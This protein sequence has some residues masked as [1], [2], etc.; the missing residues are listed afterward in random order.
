MDFLIALV[1][2]A[3]LVWGAV[4]M[5]R[6]SLMAGC[7]AFVA[8]NACLGFFFFHTRVGPV[9]LT[10]DRVIL[11]L[12]A[13]AYAIH[14]LVGRTDPK[15]LGMADVATLAF[16]GWLTVRTFTADWGLSVPG[17]PSPAWHLVVGYLS[18]LVLYWIVR[19]SPLTERNV[20]WVQLFF[21]GLGV[22]LALTAIAEVTHQWW[23]V[24][25]KHIADPTVGL[26][27]GR[28]RGPMVQSI[29]LGFTLGISL[30]STWILRERL[31]GRG[32]IAMLALAAL[33]L[34]GI[35]FTYT[36]CVW[37]GAGLAMLLVMGLT[38]PRR[39]SLLLVGGLLSV[40]LVVAT[41]EW[42]T[43][44][45]LDAGRSAAET[46]DS[47]YMR[48]SFAYVS[49]Q[50]FQDHPLFGIGFGQY[51]H[52]HPLYLSDRS[53]DLRLEGIRGQLLH[54][55]PLSILVETG[56]IGLV[57]MLAMLGAWSRDAWRL[58]N[59]RGLPDWVRMHGLL[60][61]GVVAVYIPNALFQPLG[62]MN[63]VHMMF[64][65]LSGIGSGLAARFHPAKSLLPIRAN[66]S[67]VPAES[68]LVISK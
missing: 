6:G 59:D 1:V 43:L 68:S 24:F 33:M 8:V 60:M 28:A 42:D 63:P 39:L 56:L 45:N 44:M 20:R 9:E 55:L 4:Y 19:Q 25:P 51:P 41:L 18:P 66:R 49:W 12:L 31:T 26:H 14:R 48:A 58:W 29:V 47:T 37:I 17:Q 30:I 10:L 32:R 16:L 53:T 15:P 7:L 38:L 62:H 2:V 65:L 52:E 27:F 34:V 50:M 61:L 35:F 3:A 64:F 57:L 46:R 40:S 67:P 5:V 54:N 23:A 21:V 22:Y 13:G 36:R 11:L